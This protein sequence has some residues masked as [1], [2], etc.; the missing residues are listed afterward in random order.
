MI[1]RLRLP[2]TFIG[3]LS[4]AGAGSYLGAGVVG[5][6]AVASNQV[7]PDWLTGLPFLIAFGAMGG[8]GAALVTRR[9]CLPRAVVGAVSLPLAV[10]AGLWGSV[11]A[12]VIVMLLA[13]VLAAI[14]YVHRCSRRS[15]PPQAARP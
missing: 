3:M 11:H 1:F 9:P 15:H 8:G 4:V 12:T 2:V 7:T 6:V 10:A 13:S 14:R 5:I